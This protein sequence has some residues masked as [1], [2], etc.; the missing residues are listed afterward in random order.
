MIKELL[1]WIKELLKSFFTFK[2]D[3]LSYDWTN[4][5]W[6]LKY[7]YAYSAIADMD[8]YLVKRISEMLKQFNE[9]VIGYPD[10]MTYESFIKDL[11][12][13]QRICETVSSDKF[14]DLKWQT[15]IHLKNRIENLL[16]KYL[17]HLW[18]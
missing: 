16:K 5:Y 8:H 2:W 15:Q 18:L 7:G 9:H 4:F 6:Y 12:E 3:R 17:F 1:Y 10:G 13:L 11:K 14:E